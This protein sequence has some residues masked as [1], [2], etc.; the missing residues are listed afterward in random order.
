MAEG[1]PL[2]RL[3]DLEAK[4][5]L[6][7]VEIAVREARLLILGKAALHGE[8]LDLAQVLLG[9]ARHRRGDIYDPPPARPWR[10]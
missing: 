3:H 6:L 10:R 2:A 9:I 7:G 5:A 8:V 4:P 1:V